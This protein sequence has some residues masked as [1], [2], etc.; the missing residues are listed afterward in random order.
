MA[1]A[2]VLEVRVPTAARAPPQA[3]ASTAHL[4]SVR[5]RGSENASTRPRVERPACGAN[6]C[7]PDRR[8]PSFV[9]VAMQAPTPPPVARPTSERRLPVQRRTHDGGGGRVPH[10]PPGLLLG[11]WR[12]APSFRRGPDVGATPCPGAVVVAVVRRLP[13]LQQQA[14]AVPIATRPPWLCPPTSF[15]HSARRARTWR[16]VRRRPRRGVSCVT[17]KVSRPHRACLCVRCGCVCVCV[18]VCVCM[19]G[20]A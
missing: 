3:T 16:E 8:L 4:R 19:C 20:A 14:G 2:L 17:S 12:W 9:H 15:D 11:K 1:V 7:L 6:A 18:Y 5:W 13:P 10:T